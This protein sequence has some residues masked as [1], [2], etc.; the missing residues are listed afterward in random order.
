MRVVHRV[1]VTPSEA[2]LLS[3]MGVQ[4]VSAGSVL[5]SFEVDEA[6]PSWMI[7]EQWVR[8]HGAVDVPTTLF[9]AGE[10]DAASWLELV[11]DWHHAYPQPEKD[12]GYLQ[13][14]FDGA[15]RCAV[16]VGSRWGRF[17]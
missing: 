4:I 3:E 10:L 7:V 16:P 12:F 14:T 9:T 15:C 11:A 6:D 8:E 2:V 5:V 17:S 13:V 1:S